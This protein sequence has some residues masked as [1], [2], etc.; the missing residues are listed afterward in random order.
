M[1]TYIYVVYIELYI[2]ISVCVCK[3]HVGIY[4]QTCADYIRMEATPNDMIMHYCRLKTGSFVYICFIRATG[5]SNRYCQKVKQAIIN[6]Q[7][8]HMLSYPWRIRMYAVYGLP[9][10]INI[11]IRHVSINLPYIR[12]RHGI[13][14][15]DF[16]GDSTRLTISN[17]QFFE[18][19]TSLRAAACVQ[20]NR[21]WNLSE[22]PIREA[23]RPNV[24]NGL[25]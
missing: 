13:V 17:A 5:S 4:V 12:I 23:Q 19:V 16:L 6:C 22:V 20:V 7:K 21:A 25:W 3:P 24:G 10:T 2:Y 11:R 8:N 14:S 18:K 1:H 9:F 15:S